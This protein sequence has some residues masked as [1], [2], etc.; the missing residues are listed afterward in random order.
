MPSICVII[1]TTVFTSFHCHYYNILVRICQRFFKDFLIFLYFFETSVR[2]SFFISM[3]QQQAIDLIETKGVKA[4]YLSKPWRRK[5]EDVLKAQNYECQEC[6]KNHRPVKRATT[7]HHIKHLRTHPELAFDDDNLE[8]VCS[9]C[10]NI[11]HPEKLKGFHS[12]K[13]WND[14]RW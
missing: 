13:M 5:R 3:T 9:E 2:V 14:E 11:L 6:K 8:A 7:V 4:F 1:S 12:K 10:H